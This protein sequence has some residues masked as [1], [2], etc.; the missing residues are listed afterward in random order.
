M[1]YSTL[2]LISC[3]CITNRRISFLVKTMQCFRAQDYKNKELIISYPRNDTLT[4]YTSQKFK[5]NNDLEILLIARSENDSLGDARNDAIKL[6]KGKYICNWDDDDWHHPNRLS[7]QYYKIHT[8]SSNIEANVLNQLI[9]FDKTR[10]RAYESFLY[11]WEGTLMCNTA[12]LKDHNYSNKHRGEDSQLL[13]HLVEQN[14]VSHIYNQSHLYVY[15][16]HGQNTW[17]YSHFKSF[18]ERSRQLDEISTNR[19]LK[20]FS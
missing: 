7:I 12:I 16:I 18:F 5:L 14:L 13:D 19:I 17:N 20:L 8:S 15:L 9:L 3:V 10:D 6:A 11:N 4:P 2:P 1:I